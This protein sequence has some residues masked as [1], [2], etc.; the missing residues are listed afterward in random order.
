[1]S[2]R[3]QIVAVALAVGF[4]LSACGS[5]KA[6]PGA[7]ANTTATRSAR[8]EGT[9]GN[10][11]DMQ[12]AAERADGMLDDVLKKIDPEV[13]WAHG[14]TTKGSCDVTRRRTVM[15]IVSAERRQA[16]LDQVEEF[17][18]T[19]DYR[20]RAKNK[21]AEFPAVYAVTKDG[22]GISVSVRA[23]GQVFFEAD[24]PCVKESKV[25]ESVSKPNGPA[26]K[27]VY[28]LPSP[29]VRSDHWSAGAS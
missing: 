6:H 16:F 15:T 11:M 17:W 13:Q 23:K 26:Y 19:S 27:G 2:R 21:D 20:I 4:T 3:F 10:N 28:P 14:P 24:T 9:K 5:E 29:N 12:E 22:F 1:M 8:S 7:D 18:R 25:A